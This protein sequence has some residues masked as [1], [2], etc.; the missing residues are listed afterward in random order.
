M[1]AGASSMSLSS[2]LAVVVVVNGVVVGLGV[3][4]SE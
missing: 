2:S 4:S 3:T 1:N